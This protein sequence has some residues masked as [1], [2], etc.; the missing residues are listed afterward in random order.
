MKQN[1]KIKQDLIKFITDL[2]SNKYLSNFDEAKT[3]QS[4]VQ[5]LFDLLDW[6]IFDPNEVIPE[7]TPI[8]GIKNEKLRVDYALKHNNELK[9]FIEVKKIGED[10]KNHEEQL[11]NYSYREGVDLA[12][13]T[14]GIVWWFY[15]PL[16]KGSWQERKFRS[17]DLLTYDLDFIAN[18][19]IDLLYK[20]NVISGKARLRAKSILDE[21]RKRV[22]IEESL[23]KAWE[24]VLTNPDEILIKLLVE[25]TKQICG[26]TPD[27]ETVRNFIIQQL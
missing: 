8:N 14:N 4:I 19:F 16:A 3:K 27:F 23:P 21:K 18:N 6:N 24:E 12:V 7:Y 1:H 20:E 17:I 11:I 10:L 26:E 22:K 2:R 9:A 25:R 15:L 13:L 5:R